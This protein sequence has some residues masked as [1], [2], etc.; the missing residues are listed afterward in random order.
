VEEDNFI[1]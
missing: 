1:M